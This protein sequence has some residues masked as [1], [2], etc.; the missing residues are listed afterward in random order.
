MKILK[1]VLI[2]LL[3]LVGL[4]SAQIKAHSIDISPLVGIY[5]FEQNMDIDLEN[6]GYFGM[7]FGY[8][9]TSNWAVEATGAYSKTQTL[10][11]WRTPYGR[12]L[13]A[14][15]GVDFYLFHMDFLY[16]IS[17]QDVVTPYVAFGGGASNID[18]EGFDSNITPM[19]NYGVGFKYSIIE[20]L[21]FRA[22]M[23]HLLAIDTFEDFDTMGNDFHNQLSIDVGLTYAIGGEST[24]IDKDGIVNKKDKCPTVPEDK[25]GF[26][27]ED[28]C[29]DLDND[30]DGIADLKDKCPNTPEDKDGFEDEDGCPDLDNDKD[31]IL[32]VDDKCPNDPEDFDGFQDEDG[33][34]D[35][36]RDGD[37]IQDV[38]DKCPDD[39]EDFDGFEDKDGCP[40]PDNDKDGILDPVDKCPNDAETFN[41]FEDEDGCPD[42]IILKKDDTINLDNIYFKTGKAELTE[43]SFPTLNSVK[44]IFIDNPGIVIQIEGHTDSQGSAAYNKS[45]SG[46]RAESV[47][48]YLT[49][50]LNIPQSQ[51][52]AVGFGED[53]PIA[54]NKTK[55]GRAKNRRIEF[56]VMSR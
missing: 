41:G 1:T 14:D 43:A 16:H 51:L 18:P 3:F 30:K 10:E 55:E 15:T 2:A 4:V 13:L 54:D 33:C 31:G 32:D 27:D 38:D 46:K 20:V 53:K 47:M 36:D 45:L 39:P 56:R 48:N 23:R 8:N 40:E 5:V 49:T 11:N 37:G 7:R 44:R 50:K 24:D 28:G 25:D 26:E 17:P 21:A 29:P 6:K 52:T 34:P 42:A 35:L 9:I 12:T 19:I 22:D